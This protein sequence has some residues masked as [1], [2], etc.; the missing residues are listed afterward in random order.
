[1]GFSLAN[2]GDINR[3]GADDV[4]VG[5]PQ[6][7]S[8]R[9][10]VR[11]I[12]GRTGN[13]IRTVFGVANSTNEFGWSVSSVGDI[14]ADGVPDF[15]VGSPAWNNEGKADV[16]SGATGGL[17]WSFRASS[18]Q[19]GSRYGSS[20]GGGYDLNNNGSPDAIVG[21]PWY[22]GANGQ[23]SGRAEIWSAGPGSRIATRE[24][25]APYDYFGWS[26][27][28]CSST[29]SN[30]SGGHALVGAPDFGS[31]FASGGGTGYVRVFGSLGL[32]GLPTLNTFYGTTV[33]DR[34]GHEVAGAGDL[35]DDGY[36]DIIIGVIQDGIGAGAAVGPGYVQIRS[37]NTGQ[38]LHQ[39][40]GTSQGDEYG[41]TVALA[42]DVN[43]DA[44]LD[45][46]VGE[47]FG[48]IPCQSAGSY[49]VLHPRQAPD[50]YK[51]MITEVVT[52]NP[53][54]VE[55][56]NFSTQTVNLDSW[57][58][59]LKSG[60]LN[61]TSVG[62][63]ATIAPGEIIVVKEP[64]G[65]FPEVPAGTQ[66]LNQLPNSTTTWAGMAVALVHR[67]GN[68]IDEVHIG[69]ADTGVYGEGNL[70]GRFVGSVHHPQPGPIYGPYQ[71]ER[72]WGL[73]SNSGGDW[74][75]GGVRSMGLE[76][77]GVGER[78]TDPRGGVKWVINEIDD[79]PDY[80]ELKN[81][82]GRGFMDLQG[83]SL[84]CSAGQNLPHTELRP[85]PNPTLV[86][87]GGY[88]VIGDTATLPAELPTGVPYRN[89]AT[90]GGNIPFLSGELSCALYDHFGRV[91]DVVRATRV[92]T[93]LVHNHPRAPAPPDAFGYAAVRDG[94]N[95]GS[96]GRN[97]VA[98]DHNTGLDF[99]PQLARSMG[100]SNDCSG[101]GCLQTW[102]A[103]P[104]RQMD[105]RLSGTA[106]GGG[107]TL[108]INAGEEH[109]GE[110][111]S[112]LVSFG[113]LFGTGP[114]FGLGQDAFLN[115]QI[116]S[117]TP[118]W[119]GTLDARGSARLDVP[120]GALPS[121]VESDD[122]FILQDPVTGAL[123]L[124]TKVLQWDT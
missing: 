7:S 54:G 14:N 18:P 121:G 114:L 66:V 27:A 74:Y 59:R 70:G 64:A 89:V 103:D 78:G 49:Q 11:V 46:I 58:I 40:D 44:V 61:A 1:M 29:K 109:A 80:I 4:L 47:P 88:V 34:F 6:Y 69:R 51:V 83:W 106:L 117:V 119:F 102:Q 92:G 56:T 120:P 113:H 100:R 82:S 35:D 71:V 79:S 124:Y 2:A 15:I 72:T 95:G 94:S 45:Y 86:F 26:V 68:V 30:N 10:L 38:V 48:D 110:T 31:I 23:D 91:M 53:A 108:I 97:G 55:I 98:S 21:A 73:D 39:R 116:L 25:D 99:R 41:W 85:F 104:R 87:A 122:L 96:F 81:V 37:G 65:S 112:F 32:L 118:P 8:W 93:E 36:T 90:T 52:G 42:G 3:D 105:V 20:V 57:N 67:N 33:G 63:N 84:L 17:F 19:S 123:T 22:D 9:G 12:N 101:L 28:M 50:R 76:N 16:F 107:L 115:W 60:L 75:G 111:W 62:L 13:I 43:R 5:A 24:G 77:R